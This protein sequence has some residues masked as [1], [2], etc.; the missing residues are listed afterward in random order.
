MRTS[1][2]ALLLFVSPLAAADMLAKDQAFRFFPPASNWWVEMPKGDWVVEKEQKRPDGTGFYY[3]LSSK[4]RAL[5]FSI[6]L[7]KT[8]KC[9]SGAGCREMFWRNPSPM[10]KG[11]K[12][13]EQYE[14]NG[15]HVIQFQVENPGGFPVKQANISAHA[16]K[17]G[18]W[19]D[20]HI[21]KVDKDMPDAA[22]LVAA[23]QAVSF[24]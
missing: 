9:N 19:I 2:V 6:Y 8:N 11:A 21:S 7:D 12:A 24:K 16:Y 4:S 22:P 3:L 10:Y 17:D 23:L 15:F 13:V 5:N 20:V 18:Y 1:L 14:K